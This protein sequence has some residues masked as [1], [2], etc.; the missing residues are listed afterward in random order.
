MGGVPLGS[1]AAAR[2]PSHLAGSVVCRHAACLA[3]DRGRLRE[4]DW[5]HRHCP[6]PR[7]FSRTSSLPISR[8]LDTGRGFEMWDEDF[9]GQSKVIQA[10][11]AEPERFG[12]WLAVAFP[13]KKAA[14]TRHLAHRITKGGRL[15]VY[16]G[17]L[18]DD[19]QQR[20]PFSVF[21]EHRA[22]NV[23]RFAAE[24]G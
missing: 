18:R 2:A 22:G 16:D 6:H 14:E 12:S 19:G 20:L 3:E 7:P 15:A 13:T 8:G 5:V 4:I 23:W 10:L 9:P 1:L 17:H 11:Q 21:E 24:L